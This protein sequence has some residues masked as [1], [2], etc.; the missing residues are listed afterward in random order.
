MMPM[1]TPLPDAP[2]CQ[3]VIAPDWAAAV[4]RRY[5]AV[6]KLVT[7]AGVGVGVG[8]GV[9]TAG[10]ELIGVGPEPPAP[11]QAASARDDPATSNR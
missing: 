6:S 2:A 8:V 4:D 5:S 1:V 7:G 9:T 10:A 11:P 3:A